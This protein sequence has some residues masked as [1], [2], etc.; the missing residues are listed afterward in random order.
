MQLPVT[1]GAG[2][3]ITALIIAFKAGDMWR[4]RKEERSELIEGH[5]HMHRDLMKFEEQVNKS[6]NIDR[7]DCPVCDAP[8]KESRVG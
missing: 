4:M 8:N 3:I 7:R 2:A 5:R 6:V 1:L